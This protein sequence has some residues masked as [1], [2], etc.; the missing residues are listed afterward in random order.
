MFMVDGFT[1]STSASAS[2]STSPSLSTSLST[3]KLRPLHR[4]VRTGS[5]FSTISSKS[6]AFKALN[7][8]GNDDDDE[9]IND[10]VNANVNDNA[11]INTN[12]KIQNQKQQ[13]QEKEIIDPIYILPITTTILI[14]L[15]ISFL[16]YTKMT[17]PAS[18]FDID[19]YMALDGTMNSNSNN[20]GVG[21]GGGV[22]CDVVGLPPLSPAEK[23]VGA[24]FGPPS[25][26]KY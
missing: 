24:L 1:V 4:I 6:S 16:V 18:T 22:G 12:S 17:N 14:S 21:N 25:S 13:Q 26:N 9:G 5:S 2:T 8:I 20:N 23:M 19:F 3:L 10:N 7:A 11:N 15:G